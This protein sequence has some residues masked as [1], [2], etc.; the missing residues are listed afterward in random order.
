MTTRFSLFTS[1]KLGV[2]PAWKNAPHLDGPRVWLLDR[3]SCLQCLRGGAWKQ[4]EHASIKWCTD[5]RR[6]GSL[7]AASPE[8]REWRFAALNLH[9]LQKALW[10]CYTWDQTNLCV[11]LKWNR[12]DALL[13]RCRLYLRIHGARDVHWS[14]LTV[15]LSLSVPPLEEVLIHLSS[16]VATWRITTYDVSLT[17]NW[18]WGASNRR[19][20]TAQP[21]SSNLGKAVPRV[22]SISI[23][24][25]FVNRSSSPNDQCTW[26]SLGRELLARNRK[27]QECC[28]SFRA[29]GTN[30]PV[31]GSWRGTHF[32][33]ALNPVPSFSVIPNLSCEMCQAKAENSLQEWQKR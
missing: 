24:H 15:A 21:R 14:V 18:R 28:L 32:L 29:K 2:F 25:S 3:L 27:R 8:T 19:R 22:L 17:S 12:W 7:A 1:S 16:A 33:E 30:A 4:K 13:I 6:S 9:P 5:T 23:S 20:P 26:K 31:R 10:V 11:W